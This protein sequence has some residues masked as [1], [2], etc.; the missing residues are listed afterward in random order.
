MP[1]NIVTGL[2]SISVLADIINSIF[3][4]KIA[5]EARES[6]LISVD[7]IKVKTAND[8]N[9]KPESPLQIT[10]RFVGLIQQNV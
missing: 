1:V 10:N 4:S 3:P 9:G 8:A 6:Q 2:L 5:I 7:D